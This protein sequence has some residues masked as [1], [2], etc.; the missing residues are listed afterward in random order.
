MFFLLECALAVLASAGF[1]TELLHVNLQIRPYAD[2]RKYIGTRDG[3]V[4]VLRGKNLEM[5]CRI[6]EARDGPEKTYTIFVDGMS[7]CHTEDVVRVCGSDSSEAQEWNIEPFPA[8]GGGR[9][10]YMIRAREENRMHCMTRRDGE[11]NSLVME[12]CSTRSG[13][14]RWEIGFDTRTE[15]LNGTL[16]GSLDRKSSAEGRR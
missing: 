7:I 14:Q 8:E 11:T 10:G 6:H 1:D 3:E 2:S 15:T 4:A 12:P 5:N 9:M 13:I 16:L